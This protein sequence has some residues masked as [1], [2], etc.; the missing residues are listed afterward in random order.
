MGIGM[1][2]CVEKEDVQTA[3]KILESTGEKA[4]LIGETIQGKGV[5]LQ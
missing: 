4:Y 3:I 1:V 2:V 5:E